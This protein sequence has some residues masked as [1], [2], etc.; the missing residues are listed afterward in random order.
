MKKGKFTERPDL[1]SD[2]PQE[3]LNGFI[4]G[5]DEIYEEVIREERAEEEEEDEDSNDDSFLTTIGSQLG[6]D[7]EEENTPSPLRP[8]PPPKPLSTPDSPLPKRHIDQAMESVE[9]AQQQRGQDPIAWVLLNPSIA[10]MNVQDPDYHTHTHTRQGLI[11]RTTIPA[12]FDI[13]S[14]E[15]NANSRKKEVAYNM[16]K[17]TSGY[18]ASY[19][20]GKKLKK[21]PGVAFRT[22]GTFLSFFP[23]V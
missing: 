20:L 11:I 7:D 21:V 14:V 22:P 1:V 2:I 12:G 17:I 6:D 19:T 16:T 18:D 15:V 9:A 10:T 3:Q 23:R 4:P 13:S 5:R 8:S